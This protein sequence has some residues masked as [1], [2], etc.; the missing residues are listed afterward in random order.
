MPANYYNYYEKKQ[1]FREFLFPTSYLVD[2]VEQR[3]PFNGRKA[4][5]FRGSNLHHKAIY[6]DS[7][8]QKMLLITGN[9]KKISLEFQQNPWAKNTGSKHK[10]DQLISV[11]LVDDEPLSNATNSRNNDGTILYVAESS[12]NNDG[13]F[14]NS[15]E[16]SKSI[17]S[18]LSNPAESNKSNDSHLS[19]TDDS[20]KHADESDS[21]EC[22]NFQYFE[23]IEIQCL[24]SLQDNPSNCKHICFVKLIGR[25]YTGS[26]REVV[27]GEIIDGKDGKYPICKKI[28][29]VDCIVYQPEKVNGKLVFTGV[30]VDQ[31]AGFVFQIANLE[32]EELPHSCTSTSWWFNTMGTPGPLCVLN[33]IEQSLFSSSSE[34]EDVLED[35][36][37]EKK[38]RLIPAGITHYNYFES[39]RKDQ[40][41][42]KDS[43]HYSDLTIR[44]LFREIAV[45]DK[46]AILLFQTLNYLYP[47]ETL[48]PIPQVL[49]QMLNLLD[50]CFLEGRIGLVQSVIRIDHIQSD[51]F[52]IEPVVRIIWSTFTES[53][54]TVKNYVLERPNLNMI[55]CAL[56]D[57]SFT[58]KVVAIC[59]AISQIL[60]AV[61]LICH[62]NWYQC[63]KDATTVATDGDDKNWAQ[64][65]WSLLSEQCLWKA[66]FSGLMTA[67]ALFLTAVKVR[68]QIEDKNKF[69]RVFKSIIE[70]GES[71]PV[72]R[73][74]LVLDLINNVW[75]SV[76][77]IILTFF[78]ISLADDVS[79][80]VLNALAIT[81]V[82][83]LDEELNSRDTIEVNDLVKLTVK[84]YLKKQL[85]AANEEVDHMHTKKFKASLNKF[86]AN[87]L[88]SADYSADKNSTKSLFTA[89]VK[90]LIIRGRRFSVTN[91]DLGSD[92][93][94]GKP[95]FLVMRFQDGTWTFL[96][97]K[98]I[99]D[100][101]VLARMLGR[102]EE[103]NVIVA[104]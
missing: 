6:H 25:D 48:N 3:C 10:L 43:E 32:R 72:N 55:E 60:I 82:V 39:G 9:S 22:V 76:V 34:V 41:G 69:N 77:T 98:A 45:E 81:F 83:E 30:G 61:V 46:E 21:S 28:G 94:F 92:P 40:T 44:N 56:L 24:I 71:S 51:D 104:K 19:Q 62:I 101:T 74:L 89:K 68:A 75:L 63:C 93:A 70:S 49:P 80:L 97:E 95:K 2:E 4:T 47:V 36:F 20:K 88:V 73:A 31:Y 8:I 52:I 54:S 12:K 33:W 37:Y 103:G 86:L 59:V 66:P 5:A 65:P 13:F 38:A 23:S 29:E 26:L 102:D 87:N 42:Y 100:F 85:K 1:I 35:N 16:S 14:S 64:C 27:K 99:V 15:A 11:I 79:D 91:I 18:L 90:E 78:I 53:I 67:I 58:D 7:V 96:R 50:K 57:D 17:D 84:S